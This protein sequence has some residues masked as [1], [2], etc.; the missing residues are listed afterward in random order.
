MSD[1]RLEGR[2]VALGVTGSISAYKALELLRQL[3]GEGADVVVLLTP[4]AGRFVGPLSFAALS[5][6]PVETDVLGLLPD[7]R[8][9]HIVVA[10]AADVIVVAPATAHWLGAMASGLAADAVTATCLA[11]AAPVVVAPAM[12]GD[13]WSH[14]ATQANVERIRGWGYRIVE[15]ESGP[16]ASGRSGVGRLAE[17]GRIVDAVVEAVGNRPIRAP[18]P[19]RRPPVVEPRRDA[20]LEGRRIVVTAGGTAEPIDPVR[21]IGNRSTGRMGVAVAEAALDRGAEVTLVVGRVE[22][23]LPPEAR[24]VTATTTGEMRRVLL[25]LLVADTSRAGFDALVMAAAPADFA[26][27][28][29]ADRKLPRSGGLTLEL[30]PTPDIIAD[31]GRRIRGEL[32]ESGSAERPLAPRPI[33]VSFSAETG[34]FDRVEEKLR[35]KGVD[36]AVANDV[37]ERGSGFGSPT[38]HVVLFDPDGGREDLGILPKRVVADRIVDR[39]ARLLLERGATDVSTVDRTSAV[40]EAIP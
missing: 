37:A 16:L 23:P 14:P 21:F 10:E 9:G 32:G 8:I 33:L 27:A 6:H 34:S 7:E 26:P 29:A 24:V 11:T 31:V 28:Q 13:M 22:V 1:G 5:R 15:P 17:T 2:L 25:D 39:V 36:L 12:D 30:V 4:S 40:P 35:R 20:D 38:N 3:R 18:D 19:E